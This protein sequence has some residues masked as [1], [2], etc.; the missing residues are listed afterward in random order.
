MDISNFIML[1]YW[2]MGFLFTVLVYNSRFKKF[3]R[4]NFE[5][6]IK[7]I[8]I[9]I[10]VTIY[11]IIVF[12]YFSDGYINNQTDPLPFPWISVLFV[13]WEDACYTLPIAIFENYLGRDKLWKRILIYF[14]ILMSMISF[15][16]GHLYQG[17]LSAF[18]LSFYIPFTLDK[19]KKNGFGTMMICHTLYDIVT[20]FTIKSFWG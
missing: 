12:K 6:V 10:I 13:F 20:L 14:I 15:G 8:F 7:W 1:P 18:I 5:T 3:L 2:I 4:V 17:N 11:R 9:L 19:G 16:S